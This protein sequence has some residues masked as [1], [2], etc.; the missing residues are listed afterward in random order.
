MKKN[1]TLNDKINK[2]YEQLIKETIP[3]SVRERVRRLTDKE[4]RKILPT[5]KAGIKLLDRITPKKET[6][7]D[8]TKTGRQ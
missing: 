1:D 8:P 6:N 5:K 4:G 2:K 3:K 7:S